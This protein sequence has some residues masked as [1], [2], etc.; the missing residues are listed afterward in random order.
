MEDKTPHFS[1]DIRELM[2][3]KSQ[4]N[5]KIQ[6]TFQYTRVTAKAVC[7]TLIENKG[8]RVATPTRNAPFARH[9]LDGARTTRLSH[10][11]R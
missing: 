6:S 11:T 8:K 2:E 3:P 10:D 4:T 7:Q 5:P 1:K 9:K